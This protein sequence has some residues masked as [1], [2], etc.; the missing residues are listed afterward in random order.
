[1]F[2]Q[3]RYMRRGL[4]SGAAEHMRVAGELML[5]GCNY[6]RDVLG[7]PVFLNA[8]LDPFL[9]DEEDRGNNLA[10]KRAF[11]NANY[12]VFSSSEVTVRAV[13]VLYK[14]ARFSG[15]ATGRPP[16]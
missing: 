12:P 6:C 11:E 14:Y 4:K 13:A 7:K 1:M 10:L 2:D 15:V 16:D 5:E 9:E 3:Y 8:S